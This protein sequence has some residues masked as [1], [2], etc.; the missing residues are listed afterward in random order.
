[1]QLWGNLSIVR[2]CLSL[3]LLRLSCG[4]YFNLLIWCITLIFIYWRILA[5]P[6]INP[7][8]S[9]CISFLMYC[10]ILFAK[11]LLRN[12]EFTFIS[13]IGL[14]SSVQFSRSVVSDSLRPHESQH[15]RPPCPSPT[16]GVHPIMCFES[17]MPSGL[18][19]LCHPLLL[20]PPIPP[21]L[22]VFSMSQFFTWGSQRLE[23]QLQHQSFQW[24]PSNGLL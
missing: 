11:I 2:H 18:L 8:W 24:T 5:P 22:R 15:A 1:M 20:L 16:R 10:W 19:I 3:G 13:D 17:V 14:L 4:F 12:F 21:S 9:C 23:F 6:R 7:T